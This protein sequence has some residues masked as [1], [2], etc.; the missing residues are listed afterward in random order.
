MSLP[1]NIS[2][3][4]FRSSF[5][6]ISFFSGVSTEAME[7]KPDDVYIKINMNKSMRMRINA[8]YN[9][10]THTHFFCQSKIQ[11]NLLNNFFMKFT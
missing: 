9:C 1:I 5:Y 7:K 11:W 4:V 6:R 2:I 3:Y 8:Q 10:V